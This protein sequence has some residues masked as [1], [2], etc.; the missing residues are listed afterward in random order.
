VLLLRA[1]L[2]FRF[3]LCKRRPR[4]DDARHAPRARGIASIKRRAH[5]RGET[6]SV[7]ACLMH[8]PWMR[9]GRSVDSSTRIRYGY[10]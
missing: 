4:S 7:G 8:R 10:N 3:V 6:R 1:A 5:S 2:A 9:K